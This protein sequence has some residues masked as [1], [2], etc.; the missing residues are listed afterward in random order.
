MLENDPR[1]NAGAESAV[2]EGGKTVQMDVSCSPHTGYQGGGI[3][4]TLASL[5]LH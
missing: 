4:A 5:T 1:F 3:K 2:R